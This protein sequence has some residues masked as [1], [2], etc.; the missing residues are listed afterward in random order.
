LFSTTHLLIVG[1]IAL[2]LFGNRLPSV[3]RS[4]GGSLREFKRGMDDVQRDVRQS[5][6]S[7]KST[8]DDSMPRLEGPKPGVEQPKHEAA[9]K[10]EAPP[11]YEAPKYEPPREKVV[12]TVQGHQPT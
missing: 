9:P 2:L 7:A 11:S 12:S 5:V 1:V 3:M 6:A 10:Y 8:V 4:L